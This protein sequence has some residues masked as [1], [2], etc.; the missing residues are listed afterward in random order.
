MP[1]CPSCGAE[2]GAQ[3]VVCLKCGAAL[4]APAATTIVIQNGE[5]SDKEWLAALLLCFFVGPFGVHRFYTGHI[6]IG[7]IQLLTLGGCGIWTLIDLILIIT[8]ALKDAQGR[9]LRK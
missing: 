5:V 2:A 9:P 8:G 3:A 1:Y 7:V 4:H 6:G